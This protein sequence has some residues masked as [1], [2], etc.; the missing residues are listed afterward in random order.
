MPVEK[1]NETKIFYEIHGKG[2]PI[3]MISGLTENSDWWDER[4][5][6][7][8]SKNWMVIL[9]DNR[10]SGRSENDKDFTLKDLADDINFLMNFLNVDKAHIL[11]HSMGGMI[12]QELVLN[13]PERIKKL[14]L[15]STSCGGSKYVPPS[16]E[17]LKMLVEDKR[18][19]TQREIVEDYIKILFTDEFSKKNPDFI[20]RFI[21]KVMIARISHREYMR[22]LNA[23]FSFKTCRRLKTVSTPTLVIHGKKDILSP[24]QNAENISKLIPGAQM[25]L[26]ENSA[27]MIFEENFDDVLTCIIKFLK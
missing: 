13:Y 11:G 26:F 1:I 2:F 15:Y 12:A 19:K 24:Y 16:Q 7:E 23:I 4:L 5:I 6:K 25:I 22:Q 18:G 8:L 14:I 27:H 20:E 3:V 10:G 17:V 21:D 9:F